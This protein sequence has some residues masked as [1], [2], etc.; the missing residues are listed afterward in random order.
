M[1]RSQGALT[2]QYE[3]DEQGRLTA[4]RLQRG[5]QVARE[6]R[7]GYD[8]TG[9]LLQI[10]DSVQGEQ[11]YRYDPLDRLLEVRGELTERFLH[12]PA[13]NL[14]SQTL[15]GQFEGAR[16]QG[17]RL[18]LS[19]DRHFEYDEFGRLAIELRGKGQSL[20]T[21]YHYDCQHQLVRAEL[22]DGTTANYDYDAFGR[23][24]RKTVSRA[25]SE[26]VT[27]FVWQAN[28]LI[29]ESSYQLGNDKRRTDEQY[30]SFIYEPGSFK[31]LVQL[32]GE[33]QDA[34]VFHYQ[35]DH[36]GTPL[37]LTR[38]NGAT[39]WQVRYRAYGNV[40]REEIAE[41]ATP[42]RFQGQYFDAETSLHYNRHRYYQPETGRFIT[43]DP[44]GLAG[45]LNNYQYAPN[46]IGWV[47]PLGLTNIP[48][49]CP[50]GPNKKTSYEAETRREAFR[51]AKRDAGIPMAQQPVN[52]TR[53]ELLDGNGR[54]IMGA[55]NQPIT[56]RQYEFINAKGESIFIQ[57]HSLGHA[58]AT[59]RH[60][61][62]PHFNIR[63]SDNL[64]TGS[65]LGTHGYYNFGVKK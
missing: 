3:Y 47:D 40:W 39:A 14:L 29:A 6:R 20:V 53:P 35:L 16:T 31:P 63:P 23:R 22:P 9:N 52:I 8:R 21:R 38:D 19:G 24:I 27:E 44:I 26:Q 65:V 25:N 55:N 51:Q 64:N 58:K 17:N 62:E 12:D 45:G 11:H 61:L 28:N 34:E 37:A 41:V 30:R 10:N 7:Y 56:T 32:E 43:P 54:V 60:G 2:Q 33:G 57:E 48:G 5:K 18:L 59:P 4:L 50:P 13:G 42:L 15:G 1:R 36:L 49:Q 46:P